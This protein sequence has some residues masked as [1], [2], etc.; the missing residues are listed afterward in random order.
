MF[1]VLAGA[2][3]GSFLQGHFR[4]EACDDPRELRRQILG[5]VCMGF[6][7][8]IAVGCSIGQ[9]MS[10]FS[11][12]SLSAPVTLAAIFAGAARGRRQLI[13]GFG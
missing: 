10:A 8:V 1:G 7:G 11:V 3:A 5:G 4:W 6:D 2:L 13:T 9:G 12:L